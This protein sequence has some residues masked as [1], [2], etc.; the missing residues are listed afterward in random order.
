MKTDYKKFA[1]AS[2]RVA[3]VEVR[4]E[5]RKRPSA[6]IIQL[7]DDLRATRSDPTSVIDPI[8]IDDWI[9]AILV[10]LDEQYDERK[11]S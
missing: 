1:E 8:T 11:R 3:E 6:V 2:K 10:Y 5:R 4:A 9:D 7:I